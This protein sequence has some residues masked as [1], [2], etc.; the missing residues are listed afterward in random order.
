MNSDSSNQVK[1]TSSG[2]QPAWSPDGTR[3]AFVRATNG[4]FQIY[5]MNT[6]GSNQVQLTNNT[7][8]S[9]TPAWQTL[10]G[11]APPPP[12]PTYSV[13]GR[14]F[15]SSRMTPNDP[16]PGIGGITITISGAMSA[17][18][19]TD[20]N[21]NYFFGNLPENASFSVTPRR[22]VGVITL[23]VAPSRQILR[24]LTS[25]TEI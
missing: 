12:P 20:A 15:D 6:D 2:S 10:S 25:L 5:L 16:G 24:H 19:Q 22:E 1:I 11:P 9:L 23:R 21:G 17:T 13:S 14:V 4:I 3:I 18:T 7:V 8:D